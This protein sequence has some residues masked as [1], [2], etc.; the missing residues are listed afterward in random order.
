LVAG[1]RF[2]HVDRDG[3]VIESAS[4]DTAD[5]P[6]TVDQLTI[7]VKPGDRR[8]IPFK[9]PLNARVAIATAVADT[10]VDCEHALACAQAALRLKVTAV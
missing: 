2:F 1:V 6:S 5:L 4:F 7:M 3:S 9:D 10:V 8:S